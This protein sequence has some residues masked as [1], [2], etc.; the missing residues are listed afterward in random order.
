M[1]SCYWQR[2]RPTGPLA[3]AD[4]SLQLSGV[5]RLA[6]HHQLCLHNRR[7]PH[8]TWRACS[9]IRYVCT[10]RRIKRKRKGNE[11]TR[12][13]HMGMR[14]ERAICPRMSNLFEYLRLA[15]PRPPAICGR[16]T[17]MQRECRMVG[18]AR[19]VRSRA[20]GRAPLL[21]SVERAQGRSVWRWA[22]GRPGVHSILISVIS[23]L[24]DPNLNSPANIDAAVQMKNSPE[25]PGHS[26][27]LPPS[28][29]QAPDGRA[30]AHISGQELRFR[31]SGLSEKIETAPFTNSA[32]ML[33]SSRNTRFFDRLGSSSESAFRAIVALS[34]F[35]RS[36]P[37][38][39]PCND[40]RNLPWARDSPQS[41]GD[42]SVMGD[43]PRATSSVVIP[44]GG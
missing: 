11:Q 44:G 41:S 33:T 3:L 26:D 34:A 24:V 17:S 25:E 42:R 4:L 7:G 40:W 8:S 18:A 23:M 1:T 2:L 12:C 19:C 15:S 29:L 37:F 6:R 31:H 35:G 13:S 20:P 14:R 5:R 36:C 22:A 16:S 30:S 10:P 39:S 32:D 9:A 21:R 27:V 43:R 38:G 28:A